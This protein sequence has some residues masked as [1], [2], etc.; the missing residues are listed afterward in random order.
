M[1]EVLVEPL[2]STWMASVERIIEKKRPSAMVQADISLRHQRSRDF[3]RI[4]GSVNRQNGV[5]R[6][7]SG[8][9]SSGIPVCH[10]AGGSIKNILYVVEGSASE[11]LG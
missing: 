3:S 7:A 9:L 1:G 2:H 6:T 11:G 10:I 8:S 4:G 5:R